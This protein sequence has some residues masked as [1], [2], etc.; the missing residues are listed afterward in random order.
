V[1]ECMTDE[2]VHGARGLPV[3]WR[4]L[5][6]NSVIFGLCRTA[7]AD[8][9]AATILLPL[10]RMTSSA[11]SPAPAIS[12]ALLGATPSTLSGISPPL[13]VG[14]GYGGLGL[15][16]AASLGGSMHAVGAPQHFELG[17]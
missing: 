14:A 2:Q 16:R 5:C 12:H 4:S 6:H 17:P 3:S 11:A 10:R 1:F 8:A 15:G 7:A 13:T 9:A